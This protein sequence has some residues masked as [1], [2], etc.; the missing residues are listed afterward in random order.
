M[1][2][3]PNWILTFFHI[4]GGL[5]VRIK[6]SILAHN[7]EDINNIFG[8]E[9]SFVWYSHIPFPQHI[10]ESRI[11]FRYLWPNHFYQE[12]PERAHHT[13][14]RVSLAIGVTASENSTQFNTP[15]LPSSPEPIVPP[16][17]FTS[18][19]N[20][21]S[22]SSSQSRPPAADLTIEQIFAQIQSGVDLDQLTFQEWNITFHNLWNTDCNANPQFYN[23]SSNTV[24]NNFEQTFHKELE[25]EEEEG[26]HPLPILG[27]SLTQESE[28][29]QV[30]CCL[31]KWMENWRD[32]LANTWQWR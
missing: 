4:D 5:L 7:P 13:L 10:E 11:V 30:T 1:I 25:N 22:T 31:R 27:P 3:I 20:I 9:V 6:V 17:H 24:D 32:S 23:E 29:P 21:Q 19:L 26:L 15:E 18:G 16:N 2:P 28:L 12:D 14:S 8:I